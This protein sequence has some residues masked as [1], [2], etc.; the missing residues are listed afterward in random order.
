[1]EV[2]L[3]GGLLLRAEAEADE[4]EGGDPTRGAACDDTSG[5]RDGLLGKTLTGLPSSL[6]D[7]ASKSDEDGEGEVRP[8]HEPAIQG[9]VIA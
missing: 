7:M 8:A 9:C 5:D 6:S 2:D 3:S 4:D 1:V